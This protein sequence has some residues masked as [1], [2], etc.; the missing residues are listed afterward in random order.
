[1]R[2]VK[3]GKPKKKCSNPLH[4]VWNKVDKKIVTKVRRPEY[5][6]LKSLKELARLEGHTRSHRI[7]TVCDECLEVVKSREVK[8]DETLSVPTS[9]PV[10]SVE[11]CPTNLAVLYTL[12]VRMHDPCQHP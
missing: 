1:M 10:G 5:K 11:V 12:V 3:M 6:F 2:T 4:C 7:H 8:N 9:E